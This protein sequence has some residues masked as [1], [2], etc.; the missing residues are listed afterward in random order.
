MGYDISDA[1]H[2]IDLYKPGTEQ[3]ILDIYSCIDDHF[4]NYEEL[5]KIIISRAK[6]EEVFKVQSLVP[7]NEDSVFIQLFNLGKNITEYSSISGI[8]Y[9]VFDLSFLTSRDNFDW[10]IVRQNMI[11]YQT[12]RTNRN[13]VVLY[14]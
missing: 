12:F 5:N 8:M 14:S 4:S 9:I 11:L 10:N 2:S 3:G 6:N 1:G 13:G 7:K